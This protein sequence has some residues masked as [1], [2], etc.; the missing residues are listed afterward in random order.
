MS[1]LCFFVSA[2]IARPLFPFCIPWSGSVF[3]DIITKPLLHVAAVVITSVG[4][5]PRRLDNLL[6]LQ[7]L[8]LDH[9]EL[10]G[11]VMYLAFLRFWGK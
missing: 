11:E 10:T 4:P 9:N 2:R 7:I 3:E 5:I 6:H 1:N 8:R